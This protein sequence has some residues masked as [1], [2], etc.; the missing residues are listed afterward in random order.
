MSQYLDDYVT[1]RI[2]TK[3]LNIAENFRKK[4]ISESKYII[5]VRACL[6]RE[7]V[8]KVRELL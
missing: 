2:N 1:T 5:K 4:V 3:K 8:Y 7:K 6:N